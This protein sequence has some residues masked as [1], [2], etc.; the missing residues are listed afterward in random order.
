MGCFGFP[1]RLPSFLSL[2]LHTLPPPFS[3]PS[4]PCPLPSILL[5]LPSLPFP[6]TFSF[7]PY[8]QIRRLTLLPHLYMRYL[9]TLQNGISNPLPSYTSFPIP[10]PHLLPFLLLLPLRSRLM[11]WLY[12]NHNSP[13][14]RTRCY[15]G[16]CTHVEFL[17][18][19]P[20]P[21]TLSHLSA[22]SAFTY[23]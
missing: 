14:G 15:I 22:R 5:S 16:P 19:L 12:S 1:F 7:P 2:A 21:Y 11:R 23:H 8:L 3:L 20:A 18:L 10:S 4:F 17:L 6:F 9:P 13:K